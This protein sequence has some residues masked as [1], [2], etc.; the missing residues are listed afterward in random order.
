LEQERVI[1]G[2]DHCRFGAYY[3]ILQ[4][5]PEPLQEV[6]LFHHEPGMAQNNQ[7]LVAL[8]A[9]ADHMANHLQRSNE[10][11]AYD[12]TQNPFLPVLASF[13]D[14]GF[15][16]KFADMATTIMDRASEDANAMC[17]N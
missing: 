17:K 5:L 7:K 2:T 6:I 9:V 12:P 15:A 10:S 4:Q 13:A 8:V 14:N 11:S 16:K 1:V 3:A